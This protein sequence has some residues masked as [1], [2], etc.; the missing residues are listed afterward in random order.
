METALMMR[1]FCLLSTKFISGRDLPIYK[2]FLI[3]QEVKFDM[4]VLL[5]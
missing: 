4:R 2:H 1:V 5:E 3:S